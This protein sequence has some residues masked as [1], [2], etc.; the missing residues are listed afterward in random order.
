MRKSVDNYKQASIEGRRKRNGS[1]SY[2][3]LGK[4]EVLSTVRNISDHEEK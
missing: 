3:N 4:V 1:H 2:C